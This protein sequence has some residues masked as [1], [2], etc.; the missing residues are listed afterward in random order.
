MDLRKVGAIVRGGV[1]T[2]TDVVVGVEHDVGVST[3]DEMGRK[4]LG[5][6]VGIYIGLKELDDEVLRT[7]AA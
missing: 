4:D 2:A 7:F 1:I 3:E 6:L 5:V